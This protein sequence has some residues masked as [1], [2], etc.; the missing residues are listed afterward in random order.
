MSKSASERSGEIFESGFFCAESVL[1]AIAE[2]RGVTSDLL[3]KIATGFC[4]GV[5][6]TCGM[7]GAVSGGVM[8]IG[9][10]CGRNSTT[11]PVLPT[12][13]TVRD[14]L[15]QVE[16]RYGSTNCR[17]LT[18]CDL[19][20]DE[21]QKYFKDNNLKQKCREITETVTAI[22]SEVIDKRLSQPKTD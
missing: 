16:E 3:P 22:S 19:G 13:E 12:Y 18:G 9:L 21:G 17:E 5:A 14:M 11:E 7:C 4:A 20:T 6:R 8:A 10:F 1:L 2:N 15:K